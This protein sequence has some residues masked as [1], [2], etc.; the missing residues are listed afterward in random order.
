MTV[1]NQEERYRVLPLDTAVK[2]IQTAG[3]RALHTQ[4]C[5]F[6]AVRSDQGRRCGLSGRQIQRYTPLLA[7][8]ET[9]AAARKQRAAPVRR[10]SRNSGGILSA[11]PSF[12]QL[13]GPRPS[14]HWARET[15]GAGRNSCSA[16][17]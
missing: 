9:A 17:V 13:C 5:A 4:L 8:K 12:S 11:A 2:N 7:R 6:S 15:D 14:L 1:N 16:R 10:T 3:S